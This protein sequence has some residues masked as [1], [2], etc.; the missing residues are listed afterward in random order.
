MNNILTRGFI[1]LL[2]TRGFGRSKKD[3]TINITGISCTID[4]SS[5]IVTC[6]EKKETIDLTGKGGGGFRKEDK[7]NYYN[8][9][10]KVDGIQ[11]FTKLNSILIS[12]KDNIEKDS[13][14]DLSAIL[15]ILNIPQN[16]NINNSID[17]QEQLEIIENIDNL[18]N[19][20]KIKN[21]KENEDDNL[22]I[23]LFLINSL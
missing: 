22:E 6:T 10:I 18:L 4:L 21:L 9:K 7:E 1:G 12:C 14:E 11:I 8:R 15:T 5:V 19:I 23:L 3:V 13:D 2:L 20:D 17:I 16:K